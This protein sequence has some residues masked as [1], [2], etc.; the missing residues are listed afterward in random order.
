[1]SQKLVTKTFVFSGDIINEQ[2][3]TASIITFVASS[4]SVS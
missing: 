3:F 4:I 2:L 1:M